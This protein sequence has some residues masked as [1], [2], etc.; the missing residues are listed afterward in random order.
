MPI[1][2]ESSDGGLLDLLRKQ[3]PLSVSQLK[4]AMQVTSTA[5]RQ[6]LVRLLASGEVERTTQRLT[7]G[8]PAHRYGL[9][10]KGRRRSGSN[11]ADL[12][13][14]LW[15]EIRDIKD[16]E[17][18]RGLLQRIS[19]RLAALY[20]GQVCGSSTEEKMESL[21]SLFRERQI[22]FEVDRSRELPLLR[23]TACPYPDLAEQ[24]R[25]VC[26]MERMMV[27]ELLGTNVRLSDC[28]LD[29]HN[30]C[31]F[32]PVSGSGFQPAAS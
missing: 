17:I 19:G 4:A 1:K 26:S 22:P 5:V 16:L 32:E 15:Q 6:R 3:G 12:A 20:A 11:F 13:M 21:A 10:Q 7:R 8:R 25:T 27:S 9:T 2:T 24:D 18:R 29:G 23:A 31:T 14:T 30:C 28:R